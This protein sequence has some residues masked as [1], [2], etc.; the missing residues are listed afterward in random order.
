M[1]ENIAPLV[2]TTTLPSKLFDHLRSSVTDHSLLDS[3]HSVFHPI[4]PSSP[5]SNIWASKTTPK[6]TMS[7]ATEMSAK[8]KPSTLN[9]VYSSKPKPYTI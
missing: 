8:T 4:M 6:D 9:A 3:T 5:L 1:K 7:M 2:F